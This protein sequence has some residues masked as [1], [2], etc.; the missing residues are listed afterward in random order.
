M[1][2]R[3][4]AAGVTYTDLATGESE[5][6]DADTVFLCAG[7]FETPKLLLA[8]RCAEWPQ[9]IGN[10][11]DLVGRFL[12]ANGFFF[13]NGQ[14]DNPQRLTQ[15]LG[16]PSLVSRHFDTEKEQA[17]AKLFL[18]MNYSRPYLN[19]AEEMAKGQSRADLDRAAVGPASF[20]LYGN[21][22][23]LGQYENRVGLADGTTRFGLPKTLVDTPEPARDEDAFKQWMELTENILKT[24]GCSNV[25]S[26]TYPQRGDHA[27]C[28]TRMALTPEQGVVD[29]QHRVF[30][31]DNLFI[32]SNAVLPTLSA[33][34]PTLTLVALGYRLVETCGAELMG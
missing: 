1:A 34:N 27:A 29:P 30:G 13:A 32:L 14:A 12:V 23:P 10:D 4:V 28:T 19:L 31:T 33:A 21:V 25:T 5:E 2:S 9:G 18:T 15:E 22:S 3:A 17:T 11:C 6:L 26:G 24:M 16:F 8:S 20:Q 7:A